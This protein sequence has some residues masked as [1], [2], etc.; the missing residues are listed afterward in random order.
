M[1]NRSASIL[2]L[3]ILLLSACTK[4]ETKYCYQCTYSNQGGTITYCGYSREEFLAA[5]E[6]NMKYLFDT[7]DCK[8][9]IVP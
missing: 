6:W 5:Y 7:M 3:F 2:V 8:Q 9:I 1:L 4:D